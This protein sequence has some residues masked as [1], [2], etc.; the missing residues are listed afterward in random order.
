MKSLLIYIVRMWGYEVGDWVHMKIIPYRQQSL[1]KKCCEKLSP[2]F[3]GP[4]PIMG[5][6]GE[7]AYLLDLPATVKIH[8][9]FHVS[10][11]K[12]FVKDKHTIQPNIS[13]MNDRMEWVLQPSKVDQMRWN[14]VKRDWEYFVTWKKSA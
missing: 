2:K 11:L 4:Y 6:V 12:K 5:W 14:E 10:Q 7:V 1:A 13:M 8:R 3:F 9:I